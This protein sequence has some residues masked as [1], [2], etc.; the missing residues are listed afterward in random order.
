MRKLKCYDCGAI[1]PEEDAGTYQEYVGEFWGT[2]AYQTY[3]CC[4]EC[5][6]E[7]VGTYEGGEE[8]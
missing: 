1:F 6:S 4:P 2:P 3:N 7:D 5:N 8:E